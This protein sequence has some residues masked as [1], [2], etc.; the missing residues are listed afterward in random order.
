MATPAIIKPYF[1]AQYDHRAFDALLDVDESAS[2]FETL[3]GYE[4]LKSGLRD[5]FMRH[6]VNDELAV[7]L[8]HRHFE[9]ASNEKLVE[10]GPVSSPWP[11]A[12]HEESVM[13]GSVL[14]H[15][16][17]VFENELHPVEFRFVPMLEVPNVRKVQF[18]QAF[19]DDFCQYVKSNGLENVVGITQIEHGREA[20]Q[21]DVQLMEVTYG[22]NSIMVPAIPASEVTG[23]AFQTVWE[24]V[25]K[26]SP[27][28]DKD[29]IQSRHNLCFKSQQTDAPADGIQSRHNL[30]FKSQQTDAPADG[31]Q[32]RHNLCFKSQ[33]TD[34]PADGIQS[35]HNLCF[36]SQQTDAP[37]D[38]I[39]SRHNLCFKSQQTDAPADGIQSRHNLCFKSQQTDAPADGIQSRHNLCFKS[40][41]TDA[42]A[43]GI[44]SRHNLCFKSQQAGALVNGI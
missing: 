5:I 19:F 3:A 8:L 36:K 15:T 33:Q 39:Q 14:P 32:S 10:L 31:I 22:R 21:S 27:H 40:Q 26:P 1:E 6:G 20:S 17:R 25:E 2:L 28:V 18:T 42:P 24:F 13:G 4:H 30:C 16:W 9:M 41:Q 12:A 23:P 38:G 43:D 44:Q 11:I 35:R 34:A 37:A 29:G 7:S